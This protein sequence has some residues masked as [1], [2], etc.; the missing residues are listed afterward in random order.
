MVPLLPIPL[1]EV[2]QEL[3]DLAKVF[4]WWLRQ[5]AEREPEDLRQSKRLVKA[6]RAPRAAALDFPDGG[7][8]NGTADLRHATRNLGC[9]PA[10]PL[11]FMTE[12]LGYGVF[13]AGAAGVQVGHSISVHHQDGH[14]HKRTV[15]SHRERSQANLTRR[16]C[17]WSA[18]AVS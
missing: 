6:D 3:P 14:V 8:V 1:H 11:A 2:G 15:S 13:R 5:L 4:V 18:L 10:P 12:A 17:T 16:A 9:A 7:L